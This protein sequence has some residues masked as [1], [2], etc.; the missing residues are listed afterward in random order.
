M[1]CRKRAR[2]IKLSDA[3]IEQRILL[4]K[5]W[6]V[7]KMQQH[8]HDVQMLDKI[9]FSQQKALDQLKQE[10]NELYEAAIQVML[11]EQVSCH[12]NYHYIILA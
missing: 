9:M 6:T 12:N 5:K 10:S 11:N 3:V 7:F 8:L 1:S 2:N 4:M